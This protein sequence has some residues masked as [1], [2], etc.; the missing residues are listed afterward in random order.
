MLKDISFLL[1]K[2]YFYL[3]FRPRTEKELRQYLEK[4]IIKTNFSQE[5]IEAVIEKL[6]EQDLINDKK[7][8]DLYVKDRVALKPKGIRVLKQELMVKGIS[9]QLIDEYFSQNQINEKELIKKILEK[10]LDRLKNVD[11]QK[12]Y[13]KLLSFLI[14]RGFDFQVAKKAIEE[15]FKKE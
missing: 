4:K 2:A 1:N 8:I 6:K 10:K 9:P 3:K 7:F 13:E 5:D 12:K 14:R 11:Y 15:L